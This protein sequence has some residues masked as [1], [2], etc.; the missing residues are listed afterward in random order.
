MTK[1]VVNIFCILGI[2]SLGVSCSEDRLYENFHPIPKEG[3]NMQDSLIFELEKLPLPAKNPYIAL[4]FTEEYPFSNCYLRVLMR[5]SSQTILSNQLYN[6][7]L[8]QSNGEPLGEGFGSTYTLY[9]S[10]PMKW[11]PETRSIVVL[12]Y[13]REKQL[14]GIEAI[15]IKITKN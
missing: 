13:M 3:W 7:S 2:M 11:I 14:K 5:D 4:R 6:L 1:R 9:D 12:Q 10:L 15:G 8:F